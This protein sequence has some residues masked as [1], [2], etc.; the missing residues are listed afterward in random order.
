MIPLLGV[1]VLNR[2]DLAARMIA[3]VDHPVEELLVVIN[4]PTDKRAIMAQVILEAAQPNKNI[5]RTVFSFPSF[6]LGC[7]GS[8]NHIIKHRPAGPWWL[9]VNADIE[10]G[11]GDLQRLAGRMEKYEGPLL[12]TLFEFG[13]FGINAGCV[14]T[15][16]WFDENL[17]PMYFEDNDYKRRMK[18][19]SVPYLEVSG[20]TRH[21]TSSTI[22]SD[23]TFAA[24]NSETFQQNAAY[25]RQKWGGLPGTEAFT[26]PFGG[27]GDPGLSRRRLAEQSW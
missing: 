13:A 2:E 24:R 6:N 27:A 11:A 3:S 4:A 5:G 10:F 23:E 8:W 19:A 15:V 26:V 18:F 1:P 25:Y 12:A 7:G 14:D 16:G 22:R 17:H 9:I 21:D 20:T